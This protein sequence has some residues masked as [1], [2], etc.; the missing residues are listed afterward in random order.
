MKMLDSHLR[1]QE[2]SRRRYRS[3]VLTLLLHFPILLQYLLLEAKR[4][5]SRM[6]AGRSSRHRILDMRLSN[7]SVKMV[8]EQELHIAIHIYSSISDRVSGNRPRLLMV[9]FW[10][11]NILSMLESD[12]LKWDSRKLSYYLMKMAKKSSENSQSVSSVSRSL[13]LSVG[14]S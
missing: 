2:H 1:L 8:L 12:L 7:F 10:V 13:Y 14:N 6:Q 3:Q 4:A 9:R 11:T 5:M